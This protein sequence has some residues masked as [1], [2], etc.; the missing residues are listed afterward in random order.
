LQ[1]EDLNV[2]EF[3]SNIIRVITYKEIRW[4]GRVTRIEESG[5]KVLIEKPEKKRPLG[6]PR[7]KWEDNIKM[8]LQEV[9]WG[10]WIGFIW[11]SIGTGG[12]L[13]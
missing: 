12:A 13:L 3:S 2:P 1:S 8:D 10:A 6:R 11:L 7:C 9:R 5:Y 4:A